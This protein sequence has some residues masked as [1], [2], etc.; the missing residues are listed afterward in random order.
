[1]IVCQENDRNKLGKYRS[2]QSIQDSS[3]QY[4]DQ[5]S[6][7]QNLTH[8]AQNQAAHNKN[9]ILGHKN[10][11]GKKRTYADMS[12]SI[13]DNQNSSCQKNNPNDGSQQLVPN[14]KTKSRKQSQSQNQTA[15]NG[16]LQQQQQMAM[17]QQLQQQSQQ[18]LISSPAAQSD[19]NQ[20]QKNAKRRNKKNIQSESDPDG[21]SALIDIP[22]SASNIHDGQLSSQSLSQTPQKKRRERKTKK[23]TPGGDDD[24]I[25]QAESMFLPGQKYPTPEEVMILIVQQFVGGCS[26][27]FLRVIARAEALV[28]NGQQV[29]S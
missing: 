26:Q 17:M 2:R 4:S 5:D 1:M 29:L 16:Q 21:F 25:S 24:D 9:N 15:S 28:I 20:N 27:S 19:G 22:N 23:R 3:N 8:C 10:I 14:Q 11:M 12:A 7:S 18:N 13:D 6:Y